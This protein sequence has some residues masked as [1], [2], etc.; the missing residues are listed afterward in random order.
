[1]ISIIMW[2]HSYLFYVTGGG[3]I[4]QCDMDALQKEGIGRL[5]GPGTET[6]EIIT[7][8]NDWMDSNR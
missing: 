6:Q 3:I 7:Y 8:I 4:P 2:C 5:F 1:M